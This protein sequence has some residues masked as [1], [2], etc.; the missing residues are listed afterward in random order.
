MAF[1]G[2][3]SLTTIEIPP[4]VKSVE[5]DVFSNC[6]NLET[7]ILY[8]NTELRGHLL[9]D[10]C[11]KLQAI[12]VLDSFTGEK[13][14]E[15]RAIPD[16]I[17]YLTE[18]IVWEMSS[19][20]RAELEQRKLEMMQLEPEETASAPSDSAD[21]EVL[22]TG[23]IN[24]LSCPSCSGTLNITEGQTKVICPYCDHTMTLIFESP[25]FVI[26]HGVLVK[27][28]GTNREVTVPQGVRAIGLLAFY[29]QVSLTKIVLPDSVTELQGG[30]TGCS[31]LETI[32]L[33]SNIEIIP[34]IAFQDCAS[35]KAI[36]LPVTV[37]HLGK[38]AFGNCSSLTSIKIPALVMSLDKMVF[39]NCSE[40][41]TITRYENTELTGNFIMCNK[42]SK[43][44]ILGIGDEEK[45]A[46]IKTQLAAAAAIPADTTGDDP[47][48]LAWPRSINC[49][50]CGSAILITKGQ[51]LVNCEFC[52]NQFSVVIDHPEFI[53]DEDTLVKYIGKS[54]EVVVPDA[55]K[56]IG[57]LAFYQQSSIKK[58]A[59]P[60]SVTSIGI[61]SFAGCLGLEY[62]VLPESIG[63]IS[64]DVFRDCTNLTTVVLPKNLPTIKNLF[65]T[66][67]RSLETLVCYKN[68]TLNDIVL[69]SC[70]RLQTII[71][72]DPETGETLSEMQKK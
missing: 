8:E 47:D 57:T 58:I 71:I 30:F 51:S 12:I 23:G 33:S 7:I 64:L 6:D 34:D 35:L 21:E 32:I 29:G 13:I 37:K 10:Y 54:R 62:I 22:V 63:T 56:A 28:A 9:E 60:D 27:Y 25:D 45:N 43:L 55:V 38:M 39:Y 52:H 68:T 5:R 72:L 44:L 61:T 3:K 40:L 41:E 2:C 20:G 15:K 14:A 19:E 11:A 31:S 48:P 42:L 16:E 17:G 24:K 67:F 46:I 36:E 18:T 70:F 69:A 1:D 59:L 65:L 53:M 26:D 4:G 66:K 49:T 50:G